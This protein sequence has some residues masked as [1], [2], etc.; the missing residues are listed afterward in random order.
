VEDPAFGVDDDVVDGCFQK[1]GGALTG[2]VHQL[3]RSVVDGRPR[4]LRRP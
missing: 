2:Q 4:E 3:Q 1:I